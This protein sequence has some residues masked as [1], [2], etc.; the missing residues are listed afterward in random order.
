MR[1]LPNLHE[2]EEF[3]CSDVGKRTRVKNKLCLRISVASFV[4][5][6]NT[7]RHGHKN[8]LS[9]ETM[10][11]HTKQ[12]L[13]TDC[14]KWVWLG[15]KTQ[16]LLLLG[17]HISVKERRKP[18]S[19]FLVVLARPPFGAELQLQT[20]APGS[21]LA[22]DSLFL[23]QPQPEPLSWGL[24]G[25]TPP[26]GSRSGEAWNNRRPWGCLRGSSLARLLVNKTLNEQCWQTGKQH[27]WCLQIAKLVQ[28]QPWLGTW[29]IQQ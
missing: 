23:S 9:A 5:L 25:S 22:P 4:Y 28:S 24:H 16:P 12:I 15:C 7:K 19:S 27:V 1:H 20:W 3:L 8:K 21:E 11:P 17:I 26:A 10:Q 18:M 6:L 14:S 13:L 29:I 2:Y